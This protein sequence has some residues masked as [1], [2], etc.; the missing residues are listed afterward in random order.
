MRALIL[1]AIACGGIGCARG[2][3]N[4]P[5]T[6]YQPTDARLFDHSVDF[7]ETPVIVEG[8]WRGAF[9]QRVVRADLIAAVRVESSVAETVKRQSA[10]RIAVRVT[11][12]LKGESTRNIELR[13]DDTQASFSTVEDHE[14]RILNERWI[15]FIKWEAV[16]GAA[17][18]PHWHLSPD[19]AEVRAKIDYLLS[20]P[21][22][23]PN[24]QVEVIAP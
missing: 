15:A 1:V 13:V 8:E 17:P 19:T 10:L 4:V 11:D 18:I 23:D 24:T 5:A 3:A 9:E 21:P 20:S 7:V 16:E 6:A 12:R 14:Q 22:P 2:A